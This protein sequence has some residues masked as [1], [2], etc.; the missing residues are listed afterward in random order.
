MLNWFKYKYNPLL[1]V[2]LKNSERPRDTD[3]APV[4]NLRIT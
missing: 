4:E 2:V 1:F 3:L